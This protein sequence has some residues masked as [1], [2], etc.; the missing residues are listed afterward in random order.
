VELSIEKPQE[1]I[2]V[3]DEQNE[4]W[5]F[6]KRD[7]GFHRQLL[8]LEETLAGFGLLKNEIRVYL[9]LAR[10]GERKAAE[11]ADALSLHR[12]ETYRILRELEKKGIVFSVFERPLKFSAV[13]IEKAADLLIETQKMKIKFLEKEKASLVQLWLSIPQ[14]KMDNDKKE[15]FQILE[16]LQQIILKANDLLQNAKKE[17]QIFA[18]S[19]FLAQLYHGDFI[20]NLEMCSKRLNITLLTE[21][22]LKSRFF[23][24]RMNGNSRN[25]R[26]VEAKNLPCFIIVDR[27]ELLIAIRQNEEERFGIDKKKAKTVA[28]W[29]NYNSFIE[30]LEMLFSKLTETGKTIQQVFIN[31][32]I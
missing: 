9:Y 17:I 4:A 5:K 14:P 11:A 23:L 6:V 29:T 30:T 25:Y 31:Q 20:D 21:N 3:Y 12:T 22:S 24:E 8:V 32:T 2:R 10:S 18:P 16:G 15:I 26:V 1:L 27:R 7:K 28:L 13:P 19:G